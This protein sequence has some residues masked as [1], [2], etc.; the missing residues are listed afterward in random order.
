MTITTTLFAP[1][2]SLVAA[3][4]LVG[5]RP[6]DSADA[7]PKRIEPGTVLSIQTRAGLSMRFIHVAPGEFDMGDAELAKQSL[8]GKALTDIVG[9]GSRVPH[10]GLPIRKTQITKQ[11]YFAET[12]TTTAQYC[13]FLNEVEG[14]Q[15]Y[16]NDNNW[17]TIEFAEGKYKPK[18]DC[19]DAAVSTATYSGAQAFC[20]WL[21]KR[22]GLSCRLPTEAEWEFAARGPKNRRFAWGDSMDSVNLAGQ[23]EP[24]SVYHYRKAATPEGLLGMFGIVGEWCSDW[25]APNFDLSDA[26]DPTGPKKGEYK[27]LKGR[28]MDAWIRHV[29]GTDAEGGGIYGFRI[30]IEVDS[31]KSN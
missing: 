17:T 22:T 30:V 9:Q 23:K 28:G 18:P 20:E 15:G 31:G 3:L 16:F 29:G 13:E 25:H 21:T 19:A 12:K 7:P 10:G 27:V 26:V 8:A 4:V 6:S 11:L 1:F 2:A 5:A 24:Q 14:N